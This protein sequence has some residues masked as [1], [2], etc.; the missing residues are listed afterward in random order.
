[1]GL[2][3]TTRRRWSP[4]PLALDPLPAD[5]DEFFERALFAEVLRMVLADEITESHTKVAILQ[6]ALT[7]GSTR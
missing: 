7:A 6:Y 3:D 4:G 2:Y 5:A 1:M